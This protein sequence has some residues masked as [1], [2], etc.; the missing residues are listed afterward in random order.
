MREKENMNWAYK[1]RR[2]NK[3]RGRK[4]KRIF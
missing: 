3:L 1:G 2:S 4:E